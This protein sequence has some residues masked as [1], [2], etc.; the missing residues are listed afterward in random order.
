VALVVL[1]NVRVDFPIYAAHRSLRT[2]IFERATGGLI[3]RE[4]KKQNRVTVKALSEV[5]LVLRDGDRLGLIGHNGSGKSTLL[6]VLAGIYEPIEGQVLV[7]GR[8]T[9][10]FDA[11]PGLDLEDSG[12]E[13][14]ITCGLLLGLSREEIEARIPDIEDFSELGQYLDLPV[15]T[16]SAGMM[17]RLGFA[18]VTA[19]DPGVLL[20]DEGIGTGDARFTERAERRLNEF[21]GRSRIVVLASHSSGM[22]KS[23]CNK[24]ALLQAGRIVDIGPVDAVFEKYDVILHGPRNRVATGAGSSTVAR[25]LETGI[26]VGE[27]FPSISGEFGDGTASQWSRVEFTGD[28]DL[29]N[30]FAEC[31]GGTVETLS[32]A[33]CGRPDIHVPFRICVRYRLLKDCPYKVIPSIRVFDWEGRLVLIS[34]PSLVPPSSRGTYAALCRIDPFTLNNGRY[35]V[36]LALGSPELAQPDHFYAESALRFEV[37]ELRDVDPRRHGYQGEFPGAT[38]PRLDWQLTRLDDDGRTDDGDPAA[39]DPS[40]ERVR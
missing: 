17:T 7:E 39:S 34:T 31:L 33:R 12:Y 38:R 20:M 1:D 8:I 27:A 30:E 29:R 2:A 11:M 26:S 23:I 3:Q 40:R 16:Y 28:G 10:L 14:I 4:G 6:K 13:N 32:G 9:P 5:S 36:G 21:V 18:L 19:F 25:E 15:R 37:S 35:S 24:A 22:I